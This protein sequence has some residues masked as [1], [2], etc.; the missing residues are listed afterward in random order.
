M[1]T[2]VG[3]GLGV[4]LAGMTKGLEFLKQRAR[5]ERG[6][7]TNGWAPPPGA[8]CIAQDETLLDDLR[9]VAAASSRTENLLVEHHRATAAVLAELSHGQASLATSAATTAAALQGIQQ[10]L[11]FLVGRQ[12]GS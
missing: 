7:A 1:A 12:G 9:R 11:T 8:P 5:D 2:A 4:G 6:P 3:L 10:L